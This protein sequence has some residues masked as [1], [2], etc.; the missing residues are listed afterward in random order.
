MKKS[1]KILGVGVVMALAVSCNKNKCY[2]CHYDGP[3][4]E[5][6]IGEKCGDDVKALEENGYTVD[7]VTYEAHCGEH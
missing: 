4:G 7:S 5:V 3:N 2:E 6:E 1:I